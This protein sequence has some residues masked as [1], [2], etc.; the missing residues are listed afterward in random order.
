MLPCNGIQIWS[1]VKLAV[2]DVNMD[3]DVLHGVELRLQPTLIKLTPFN[4]V[5]TMDTINN[6][7]KEEK[8]VGVLAPSTT[9]LGNSAPA[10]ILAQMC[11]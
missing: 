4:I 8:V 5:A 11:K 10:K 6:D 9:S 2:C 3:P 1:H 7:G